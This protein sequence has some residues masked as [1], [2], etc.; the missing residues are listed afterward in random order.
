MTRL[1]DVSVSM[2]V[3]SAIIVL[4]ACLLALAANYASRV[5][6]SAH[7]EI[8][9]TW[10]LVGVLFMLVMQRLLSPVKGEPLGLFEAFVFNVPH[11]V[12]IWRYYK[13]HLR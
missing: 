4:I 6:N 9:V 12:F 13:K 7:K 1:G 3:T 8:V 2:L 10:V 11:W 5:W